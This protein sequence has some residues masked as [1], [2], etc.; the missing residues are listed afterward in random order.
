[1]VV[2]LAV[3]VGGN[4]L[5]PVKQFEWI[6]GWGAGEE[7]RPAALVLRGLLQSPA[8]RAAARAEDVRSHPVPVALSASALSICHR[9]CVTVTLPTP[10]PTCQRYLPKSGTPLSSGKPLPAHRRSTHRDG[11]PF[12][13]C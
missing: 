2:I 13:G 8:R 3:V 1:M 10:R 11:F 12:P 6:S 5:P 4:S 9:S 7:L